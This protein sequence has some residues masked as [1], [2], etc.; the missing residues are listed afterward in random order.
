LRLGACAVMSR[1]LVEKF[2]TGNKRVRERRAPEVGPNHFTIQ[3]GVPHGR[4]APFIS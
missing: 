4:R 2:D 3:L 1:D